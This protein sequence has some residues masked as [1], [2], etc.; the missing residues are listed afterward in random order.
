[1]ASASAQ[2]NS[3]RRRPYAA[4]F[5]TGSDSDELHIEPLRN[6]S[7][8]DTQGSARLQFV[9]N[10]NRSP[11][12][13]DFINRSFNRS[14]ELRSEKNRSLIRRT[15]WEAKKTVREL[16]ANSTVNSLTLVMFTYNC[17]VK[18]SKLYL[19]ASIGWRHI[20]TWKGLE[21][22]ISRHV[23]NSAGLLGMA[24]T[25]VSLVVN[26]R[27]RNLGIVVFTRVMVD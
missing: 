26:T 14:Y 9:T 25:R 3:P 17:R 10:W 19:Y 24:T 27:L 11:R 1:M 7:D 4:R 16:F 20:P 18:Y 15:V 13:G 12:I 22:W 5:H 8:S 2:N 6:T 23:R 21:F